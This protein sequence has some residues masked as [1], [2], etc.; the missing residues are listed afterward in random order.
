MKTGLSFLGTIQHKKNPQDL[1]EKSTFSADEEGK[2]FLEP[3]DNV[4]KTV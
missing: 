3:V 4:D 2:Q 1:Q